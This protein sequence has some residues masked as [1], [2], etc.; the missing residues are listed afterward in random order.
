LS[1]PIAVS[2]S[3]LRPLRL[4]HGEVWKISQ[5]D[6]DTLYL[7]AEWIG[8]AVTHII[9]L[10]AIYSIDEIIHFELPVNIAPKLKSG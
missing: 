8:L 7:L 1:I 3:V 6:L 5:E 9:L 4:Y 10:K 2:G